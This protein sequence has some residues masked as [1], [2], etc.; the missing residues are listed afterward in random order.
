MSARALIVDD[1][2]LCRERIR[3]LLG[4]WPQIDVVGECARGAD[5]V[6]VLRSTPVELLF[7]D[8]QMPDLDG[9]GVLE[10]TGLEHAPLVVFVTAYADYAVD[11][12]EVHAFDYLLKPIRGERFTSAVDRALQHLP[13]GDAHSR[14]QRLGALLEEVRPAAGAYAERL[15]V[16]DGAR[17]VFLRT[18][19]ID[20]FEAAGNYVT[21]HVGK[22]SHLVRQSMTALERRLDPA[23]FVRVHRRA[24]VN[25]DAIREMQPDPI[26]EYVAVLRDGQRLPVSRRCR[27]RVET[28]LGLS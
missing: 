22:A 13:Q 3:V 16:R 11:A 25:L 9:F 23:C 19:D 17:R 21:V 4:Q 6:A 18:A 24:L 26:G 8:V 2:P 28:R 7:L 1:E 10:Q 12:F 27:Q 15:V 14:R 20:W 5:A